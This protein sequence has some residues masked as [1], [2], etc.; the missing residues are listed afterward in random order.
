M[1]NY[2]S[3]FMVSSI[4]HIGLILSFTNF[5]QIDNLYSFNKVNP[6]PA[7]L[8]FESPQ[9]SK[10]RTIKKQVIKQKAGETEITTPIIKTADTRKEIET[11]RAEKD[12]LI[13]EIFNADSK[14]SMEKISYYSN[15]IRNQVI[16]H[17]KQPGSTKEG[18][19]A[20][21]LITL[22]PTG[23]VIQ[24][25]LTKSS[26]NQAFDNSALNAVQKVSKF[27]DLNMGRKLFDNNFR[28]FSLIFN[29]DY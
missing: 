18:M 7:Y 10:K 13:K 14:S 27:E 25:K 22:V 9:V 17:W 24:V 21:I 2:F 16:M 26:G 29:P 8:V 1:Q 15:I 23:E 5:F 28:R 11:V 20:E 4:L 3:G 6:M 12:L 19:S